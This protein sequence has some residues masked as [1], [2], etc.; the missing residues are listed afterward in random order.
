MLSATKLIQQRLED[1][2]LECDC[3]DKHSLLHQGEIILCDAKS[4]E[5]FLEQSAD[6]DIFVLSSN[7]SL[8]EG[9]RFL[10]IGAKGYGNIYMH[11]KYLL[12]ALDVIREK[13]IWVYP[14]LK[15]NLT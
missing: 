13:K 3:F 2:N 15:E 14:K 12:Q 8:Q 9:K 10:A 7:P 11:K 4:A 1:L 6:N 5:I